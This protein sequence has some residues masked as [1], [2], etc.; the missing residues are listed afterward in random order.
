MLFLTQVRNF[1]PATPFQPFA[2]RVLAFFAI[3]ILETSGTNESK[4]VF[5]N[6]SFVPNYLTSSEEERRSLDD[7]IRKYER[8]HKSTSLTS[9]AKFLGP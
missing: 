2:S 6:Q 3:W 9:H 5:R 4:I 8:G 7:H 1:L